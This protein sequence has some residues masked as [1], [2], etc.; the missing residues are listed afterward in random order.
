M[1]RR[2]L[3][4]PARGAIDP[5]GEVDGANKRVS[6]GFSTLEDEALELTGNDYTSVAGQ[7]AHEVELGASA[8]LARRLIRS[9]LPFLDRPKQLNDTRRSA[10]PT[11]DT[12]RAEADPE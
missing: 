4:G 8:S 6:G 9:C 5:Q 2:P 3:D 12:T 7:S 11:I 1:A 10:W